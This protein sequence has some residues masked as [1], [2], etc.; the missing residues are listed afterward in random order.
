MKEVDII[1]VLERIS[2]DENAFLSQEEETQLREAFSQIPLLDETP[3]DDL[4]NE[5]EFELFSKSIIF[6]KSE[7]KIVHWRR[8]LSIAALLAILFGCGL[9]IQN[10]EMRYATGSNERLSFVL[11]DHS[12]VRLNENSSA[13]YNKFFFLFKKRINMQGEAYYVVTKGKQFSVETPKHQISVLG[14]R[15]MVSEKEHFDVICYEGKVMVE[16]LDGKERK[17]LTKGKCFI[18]D[19]IIPENEPMWVSQKYVFNN[20]PL[21]YVVEALEKEYKISIQN[22]SV[23]RGQFFTG[24]FPE[25][26]LEVALNIVLAPY[27]MSW[28]MVKPGIYR[29]DAN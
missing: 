16:S 3:A 26:N 6:A 20:A 24:S 29:V 7:K 19:E 15:F 27:N 13:E 8:Y 5:M 12:E 2:S 14:T 11:P 10:Q 21:T 1:S 25:Q 28:K 4:L 23:C 22:K 9:W 17:L 18:S